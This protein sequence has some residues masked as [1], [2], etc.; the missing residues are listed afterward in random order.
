MTTNERE[1]ALQ[2]AKEAGF[3]PERWTRKED[4]DRLFVLVAL[5]RASAAPQEPLPSRVTPEAAAALK[6]AADTLERIDQNILTRAARYGLSPF[7]APQPQASP[8][9]PCVFCKGTGKDTPIPA[10]EFTHLPPQAPSQEPATW[11]LVRSIL[12]QGA[13]IQQDFAAGKYANYEE[14]SARIDNATR[15]RADA[16]AASP[17][18]QAPSATSDDV[19]ECHPAACR[20]EMLW[21]AALADARDKA[22]EEAAR[23]VM[24]AATDGR[25]VAPHVHAIRALRT[26][27]EK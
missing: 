7:A 6:D 16:I 19:R 18:P 12:Q 13:S 2:L 26:T 1:E 14:Y 23:A 15:E 22:L 8:Q 21:R 10:G 24:E 3:H 27:S 17:Q 4:L 11:S 20:D 25:N 5:A 9:A